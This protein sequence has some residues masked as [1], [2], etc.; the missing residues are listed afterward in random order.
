MIECFVEVAV[1]E[2]CVVI[3]IG[4]GHELGLL[5]GGGYGICGL[6]L[7]AVLWFELGNEFDD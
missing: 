6:A 5:L 4:E 3:G 7:F 2:C 1:V